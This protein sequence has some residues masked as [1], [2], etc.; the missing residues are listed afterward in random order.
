MQADSHFVHRLR[1]GRRTMHDEDESD[2]DESLSE[3]CL[4]AC[5][6]THLCRGGACVISLCVCVY[7][8]VCICAHI[9]ACI[10]IR[11]YIHVY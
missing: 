3:V 8:C 2:E 5:V 6:C 4:S 1:G 9:Y 10:K 7:T 11:V